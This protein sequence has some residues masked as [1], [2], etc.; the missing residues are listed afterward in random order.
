MSTT[1][2]TKSNLGKD[3]TLLLRSKAVGGEN[4]PAGWRIAPTLNPE[5]RRG[6]SVL[7][8]TRLVGEHTRA[9]EGLEWFGPPERNTL[10][11]YVMYCFE[12][13]YELVSV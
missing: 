4:S 8:V 1:C 5:K 2:Q 7:L 13:L 10:L 9:H 11:H 3:K 12:S 6:L